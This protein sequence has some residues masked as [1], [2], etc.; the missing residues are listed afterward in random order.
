ML[1][2]DASCR[3]CATSAPLVVWH[4]CL[5]RGAP[6]SARQPGSEAC[7]PP[8]SRSA[9]TQPVARF[10][11]PRYLVHN[12]KARRALPARYVPKMST[13]VTEMRMAPTG[14]TSLSRKMGSVCEVRRRG[15]VRRRRSSFGR[16]PRMSVRSNTHLHS[17]CIHEEQS[18][19]QA[20]ALL[21]K[22]RTRDGEHAATHCL[23]RPNEPEA[24]CARRRGLRHVALHRTGNTAFAW[25]FS[26]AVPLRFSTCARTSLPPQRHNNSS[27]PKPAQRAPPPVSPRARPRAWLSTLRCLQAARASSSRRSSDN[28]PSVSPDISPAK[29]TSPQQRME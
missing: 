5:V 7:S 20:L 22:L 24:S 12:C 26:T 25:Y 21:D 18:H 15:H 14:F 28:S 9:G 19:Q 13:M 2:G 4:A 16:Q 29:T 3:E 23:S 10:H 11:L 27:Q 8:P 17:C 6:A 1:T